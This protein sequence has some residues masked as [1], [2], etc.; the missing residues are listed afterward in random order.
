MAR[1]GTGRGR[2][3]TSARCGGT[4]WGSGPPA[5]PA[6][7]SRSA[8]T[9]ARPRSSSTPHAAAAAEHPGDRVLH[10]G[11]GAVEVE[12]HRVD[13]ARA[14]AGPAVPARVGCGGSDTVWHADATL[15]TTARPAPDGL[16]VGATRRTSL[17]LG[18]HD[19]APP[20]GTPRRAAGPQ[21]AARSPRSTS[22]PL[23]LGFDL[24]DFQ[25][26]ACEAL[27]RGSGVLVCAPT[28]AGK[29][30]VGEFA[31]H[32]ALRAGGRK[33][34]YTTPIKALS[35][36]KYHDLVERHGA[37]KV[38]LLT[39][40]NAINGDAPVVV[41]T[42]EVLRNMLYAG[43]AD[44]RGPGVR[45]DGR[46]ALPGRPVPRRGL[47][48]G[49]HPPARRRSR[50]SRCRPPSPTPRSSP[51]GWSPCAARPRSWSASTGRCRCG[52]TCWSASGCST[53]STTPTRPSKHDVHP[54]LLRY[55]PGDAAPAGDERRARPGPR[56]P[57]ARA[58]RA[59]C[60]PRS[61]S[62]STA[63]AC[64]RRSCSSSA[65]PAATP[66]CSSAWPPGC[67]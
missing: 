2:P 34:F 45:G 19:R 55:T 46:G 37:D 63:R 1:A 52:S 28:G 30:V 31:V 39:G 47:G 4:R 23:E 44:A 58:G 18:A 61:S 21:Q 14:T 32:L 16:R 15:P 66:P 67:G 42:T 10:L 57:R 7:T 56:R 38:G 12:E 54:E 20:S 17:S 8:S 36:Q 50:W 3:T 24:D 5:R 64:C 41:M 26:E 48:R 22:S 11:E 65:G 25:R 62:G 13:R 6:V 27:E 59:R 51:T 53:C 40:D 60:A 29:T 49:D 33:C 9:V 43:S 35:N